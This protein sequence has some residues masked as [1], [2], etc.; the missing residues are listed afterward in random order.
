MNDMTVSNQW[1]NRPNDQRFLTLE[2][3][4][5]SV[6]ARTDR[7]RTAV[8]NTKALRVHGV[9]EGELVLSTE[10]GP[11]LFT[12]WSF[13]QIA[14]R[15]K[16]PAGYLKQLPP[17]LVA[18]N[19][20]YGLSVAPDNNDTMIYVDSGDSTLRA[21]TSSTYGRIYDLDLAD[22][23]MNIQNGIWKVPSASYA[24]KDPKRATTLYASD[25]DV[26]IFLVDDTHAI[27]VNG[28]TLF[29]GFYAWNSEVGAQVFGLA[30]FLYRTVCD[31]RIIW[32]M[33]NKTELRI[34]HTSG[35]P[36]RFLREAKPSLKA[37]SEAETKPLVDRITRAQNIV[38]GKDEDEVQAFLAKRGMTLAQS[39]RVIETAEA[40][41]E[42]PR[43]AW[44]ISQGMTAL[45]RGI[46]FTDQ[47]VSMEK[48]AGKML[49][50]VTA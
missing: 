3:L 20:N 12:N 30:T 16:A 1:R 41:G 43:S 18:D 2:D 44:G 21:I 9:E 46:Q 26:F 25:R 39:K 29:R 48:E 38:L 36:E 7:S 5:A 32:G 8:I 13:G 14:Q 42:N 15:A 37:Y 10:L 24:T 35:G 17:V 49:D 6:A 23:V 33:T 45:A 19:L 31:N 11:Q 28:E 34:K 40:E 27:E 50:A 22:A 47:R 4:R